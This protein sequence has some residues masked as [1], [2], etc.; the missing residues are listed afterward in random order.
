[1]IQTITAEFH[2]IDAAEIAARN[3]Q[4]RFASISSIDL[5]YKIPSPYPEAE[6]PRLPAPTDQIQNGIFYPTY[7]P[8][9]RGSG[10]MSGS[11]LY[12][13]VIEI[14]EETILTVK[15]SDTEARM[16]GSYLRSL[17]GLGV[18]VR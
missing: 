4:R 12:D 5:N 14:N 7:M 10:L 11:W 18:S 17:G 16:I 13:N 2:G 6:T 3:V 9:Y 1:M 15:A 8:E